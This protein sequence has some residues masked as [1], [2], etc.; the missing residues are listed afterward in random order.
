MKRLLFFPWLLAVCLSARAEDV[1]LKDGKVVRAQG[2]RREGNFLF[3]RTVNAEGVGSE[4][5]LQFSQVERIAFGD[6]PAMVEARKLANAGNA[7]AVLEKTASLVPS[8]RL[9]ADVPGNLW[10]DLVRLRLPAIAILKD[11][12]A[13]SELQKQWVVTGDADL[14]EALKLVVESQAAGDS[15]A[16]LQRWKSVAVPGATSLTAGLAWLE[17]GKAALEAKQWKEAVRAFLSVEV[18]VANYRILHPPALL[19]AI[20]AFVSSGELKDAKI[21]ME[22][23][24]AEFPNSAELRLAAELMPLP[25]VK[26]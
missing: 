25:P 7:A 10:A 11:R 6:P 19:G 18:F 3:V 5:L 13:L 17:L 8:T 4:A 23:L 26:K 16:S 9:F 24:Q 15:K 2:L 1:F 20:R 22:V 21:R 14:E 12:D